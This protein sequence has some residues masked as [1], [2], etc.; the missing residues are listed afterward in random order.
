MESNQR[1]CKKLG[2]GQTTHNLCNLLL[3]AKKNNNNLDKNT[4]LVKNT[5]IFL[6]INKYEVKVD[7]KGCKEEW[8]LLSSRNEIKV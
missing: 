6:E 4:S 2:Y 3:N 7:G 8:R 1:I 5:L